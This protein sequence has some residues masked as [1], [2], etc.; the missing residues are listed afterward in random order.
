MLAT[1]GLAILSGLPRLK[2][3]PAALLAGLGCLTLGALSLLAPLDVPVQIGALGLK[4]D[5]SF[6][7]LGRSLELAPGIRSGVG[8]I[9]VIGGY[10]FLGALVAEPGRYFLPMGVLA[11]GLLA[12][13]LMVR[14]FLY[15]AVL[16]M[17]AAAA[18]VLVL[19]PPDRHA[20]RAALRLLAFA[21]FG[22]ML[23]LISA[24]MIE[25]LGV[26]AGSPERAGSVIP[27]LALGLAALV[28][29]P[30][31]HLWLPPG[32][33]RAHPYA[34]AAVAGLMQ[35]AGLF[36]VLRVLDSFGWMR[37]DPGVQLAM[38]AAGIVM[39]ILGGIWALAQE[40]LARA[41]VYVLLIDLGIGM[42]ALGS[43]TAIGYQLA[44]GM[45]AARVVGLGAWGLGTT[46]L[47]AGM[48][49][50]EQRRLRGAGFALPLPAVL[51]VAGLLS[52]AGFPLTAGF[53]GKWGLTAHLLRVGGAQ[54][55]WVPVGVVAGVIAGLQWLSVIFA[56][57]AGQEQRLEL[58]PLARGMGIGGV[59]IVVLL[60]LFPQAVYPLII[61]VISGLQGLFT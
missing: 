12:S 23:M 25:R 47:A 41:F 6:E 22:M 24:W 61:G 40:R 31:F 36:L 51:S 38:T 53:P 59:V 34:L 1:L 7:L 44:M 21:C 52:V 58:T 60:G 26:T 3:T 2:R 33:D 8:F 42:L 29:V 32:A 18:F 14:P 15:S 35:A 5:P 50:D 4:L 54:W 19:A 28:F 56:G 27:V 39:I 30:P 45:S 9:F 16:V 20:E 43:G 17:L 37:A 46:L 11:V 57:A 55:W 49:G 10:L 13:A 48:G